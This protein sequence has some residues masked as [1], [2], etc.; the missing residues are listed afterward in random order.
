MELLVDTLEAHPEVR[1]PGPAGVRD[2][3]RRVTHSMESLDARPAGTA[4]HLGVAHLHLRPRAAREFVMFRAEGARD[5][6]D[7]QRFRTCDL[8]EGDQA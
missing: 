6:S 5:S 7:V 4:L 8:G 2:V 1:R 3:V